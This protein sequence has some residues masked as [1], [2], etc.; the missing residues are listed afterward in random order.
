MPLRDFLSWDPRFFERSPLFEPLVPLARQF[1]GELRFPTIARWNEVLGEGLPVRFQ[2]QAPAPRGQ[3]RHQAPRQHYSSLI[4]LEKVVPSR[5]DSW[6][7]FFNALVWGTFPR[8][9]RALHARQNAAVTSWASGD[10]RRLPNKRTREL[11]ALALLDE[12]GVIVLADAEPDLSGARPGDVRLFV[13]GHAIYESL[14][15]RDAP[16]TCR[17][18]K[19]VVT[20]LPGNQ[21][22]LLDL[23]DRG[24][25]ALLQSGEHFREPKREQGLLLKLRT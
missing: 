23:A 21:A 25:E 4:H 18:S 20:R 16:A 14:M 15:L 7:D 2:E 1:S 19:V 8:S 17:A 13:F 5:A 24:L 9:K 12:G 3:R 11:D 10:A 22:S 6:H